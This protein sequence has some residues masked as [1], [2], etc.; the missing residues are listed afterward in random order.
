MGMSAWTNGQGA[1]EAREASGSEKIRLGCDQPVGWF[2]GLVGLAVLGV[3]YW[4]YRLT[5]QQQADPPR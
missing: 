5:N 3:A 1:G 4:R 2:F